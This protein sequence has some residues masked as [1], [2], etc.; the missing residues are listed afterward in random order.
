M[1]Y[2]Y[3]ELIWNI[4]S[5]INIF[6]IGQMECVC[7]CVCICVTTKLPSC[8]H[9]QIE[10]QCHMKWNKENRNDVKLLKSAA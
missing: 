8:A 10:R 9:E 2:I 7:V 5:L 6:G 3:F 4:S 1:H